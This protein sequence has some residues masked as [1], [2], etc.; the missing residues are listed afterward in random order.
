MC[1]R[2]PMYFLYYCTVF[3]CCYHL[4]VADQ[5][6]N[7]E[8]PN[9]GQCNIFTVGSPGHETNQTDG[10]QWLYWSY[11]VLVWV[12]RMTWLWAE[13]GGVDFCN[14]R[15][16]KSIHLCCTWQRTLTQHPVCRS[17]CMMK[18]FNPSV[19]TREVSHSE[20]LLA[21]ITFWW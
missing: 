6:S 16:D 3:A 5:Y 4:R 8:Y 21:N 10:S 2:L 14:G 7:E 20:W 13:E 12:W 17:V 18:Q 15:Q 19:L 1:I 9:T 11:G